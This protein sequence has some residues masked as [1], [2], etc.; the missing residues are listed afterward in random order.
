MKK[1][2]TKLQKKPESE[3]KQLFRDWLLKH[4]ANDYIGGSDLDFYSTIELQHLMRDT[5]PELTIG[6]VSQVMHE[7]DF[8]TESFPDG[9]QWKM[10]RIDGVRLLEQEF[11]V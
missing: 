4:Y 1:D 9:P 5:L 8:E 7:L 10:Y 3:S 2:G 6:E 11:G